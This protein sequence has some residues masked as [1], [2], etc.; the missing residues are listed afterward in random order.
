MATTQR[1]KSGA[2]FA[3]LKSGATLAFQ[4]GLPLAL[5][6]PLAFAAAALLA[7]VSGLYARV[8]MWAVSIALDGAL[9]WACVLLGTLVAPPSLGSLIEDTDNRPFLAPV[10]PAACVPLALALAAGAAA[11]AGFAALSVEAGAPVMLVFT[12][13]AFGEGFGAGVY[14]VLLA[15]VWGGAILVGVI[16]AN[17]SFKRLQEHGDAATTQPLEATLLEDPSP[18]LDVSRWP[19]PHAQEDAPEG[20]ELNTRPALT[21]KATPQQRT[22]FMRFRDEPPIERAFDEGERERAQSVAAQ[23]ANLQRAHAAQGAELRRWQDLY[24][25]L[26]DRAIE[27]YQQNRF[28]K[29]RLQSAAESNRREAR[30]TGLQA[31]SLFGVAL[32]LMVMARLLMLPSASGEA[33]INPAQSGLGLMILAAFLAGLYAFAAWGAQKAADGLGAAQKAARLDTRTPPRMAMSAW[34]IGALMSV[35]LGAALGVLLFG[36]V[37][38][39][40][41]LWPPAFF[42]ASQRLS[43]IAAPI[44]AGVLAMMFAAFFLSAHAAHRMSVARRGA[45][46]GR[47]HPLRA[48]PLFTAQAVFTVAALMAMCLGAAIVWQ[49]FVLNKASP[50]QSH[51]L[52]NLAG[53]SAG[54]LASSAIAMQPVS[55]ACAVTNKVARSSAPAFAVEGEGR[56]TLA[57]SNC[58]LDETIARGALIVTSVSSPLDPQELRFTR[59]RERGA[60]LASAL[61]GNGG[62]RA[63]ARGFVLVRD[64][65]AEEVGATVQ[66]LHAPMPRGASDLD[67]ADALRRSMCRGALFDFAGQ[68]ALYDSNT[69]RAGVDRPVVRFSCRQGSN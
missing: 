17:E 25:G 3:G 44:G 55:Y 28:I 64:G 9:I 53:P 63:P 57:A 38:R 2:A 29:G 4:A 35:A 1:S 58:R 51:S 32:A 26:R 11:Q 22:S 23:F 7:L 16:A 8:D 15:L 66:V 48:R 18:D 56:L 39:A 14:Y 10:D 27:L 40:A 30:L 59:A 52:E 19:L 33:I 13:A 31:T 5:A 24:V 34:V 54:S 12:Q 67:L 61:T 69:A 45:G 41:S 21:T 68:F 43:R 50:V 47:E 65:A 46:P 36:V 62:F 20:V 6:L 49:H 37:D 42:E 60:E